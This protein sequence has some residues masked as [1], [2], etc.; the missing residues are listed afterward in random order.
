MSDWSELKDTVV[1]LGESTVLPSDVSP[2]TPRVPVTVALPVAAKVVACEPLTVAVPPV[3]IET[4]WVRL[5]AAACPLPSPMRTSPVGRASEPADTEPA[6][7]VTVPVNVTPPARVVAL[8]P[9]LSPMVMA[10]V[11]PVPI[12]TASLPLVFRFV[13]PP[14]L[15]SPTVETA[16]LYVPVVPDTAPLN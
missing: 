3:V 2:V 11:P 9:V 16:P 6:G 13:A 14:L 10:F 8:G 12:F 4:S 15:V 7:R 1:P 5:C